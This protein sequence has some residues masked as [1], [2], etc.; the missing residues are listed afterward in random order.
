[1]AYPVRMPEAWAPNAAFGRMSCV[2]PHHTHGTRGLGMAT[3]KTSYLLS[4]KVVVM[5][6][7]ANRRPNEEAVMGPCGH[8]VSD[9]GGNRKSAPAHQPFA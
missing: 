4:S 2:Q 6:A 9:G 1:M 8:G 7:Y 5:V 3:P